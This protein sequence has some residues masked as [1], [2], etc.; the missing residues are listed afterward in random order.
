ML[1]VMEPEVAQEIVG[2]QR[3]PVYHYGRA[4]F[5]EMYILHSGSCFDGGS[6]E[7]CVYSRALEAGRVD[8]ALESD[9]PVRLSVNEGVLRAAVR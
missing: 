8:D 6:M 1:D 7:S 2:M 3:S 5:G 4:A 9:L